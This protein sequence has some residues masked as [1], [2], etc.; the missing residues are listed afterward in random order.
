MKAA[1]DE[2]TTDVQV[3]QARCDFAERALCQ[4]RERGDDDTKELAAYSRAKLL[5]ESHKQ[6]LS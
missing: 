3:L 4:A 2:S 1:Y 5:L 6:K